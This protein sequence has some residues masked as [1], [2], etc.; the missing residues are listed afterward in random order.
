MNNPKQNR[1]TDSELEALVAKLKPP[2]ADSLD[3]NFK[4]EL[5]FTLQNSIAKSKKPTLNFNFM[6]KFK[7]I[8]ASASAVAIVALIF[9]ALPKDKGT[10][11]LSHDQQIIRINDKAF[12]SLA[13]LTVAGTGGRGGGGGGVGLDSTMSAAPMSTDAKSL[14]VPPGMGGGGG[15]ESFA[16]TSYKFIYKGDEFTI[17]SDKM[18]VYERQKGFGSFVNLDGVLGNFNIGSLNIGKFGS[19]SVDYLTASQDTDQGY[20]LNMDFR[21]GNLY[22]GQNWQRWPNVYA[23]C[24][25]DQNC[26]A[27]K[28]ITEDQLPSNEE[29]IAISNQFLDEYGIDKS[30]FGEPFVQDQWRQDYERAADKSSYY[31]PEIMSVIY[32]LKIEGNEIYDQGGNKSGM[33]VTVDARSKKVSGVSELNGQRYQASDYDTEKDAKRIISV[34]EKGGYQNYYTIM[35]GNM[36]E[37]EIELGNPTSG[38]VRLWQYTNNQSHELFVPSL[39]FPVTNAPK[40]FYAK[41][42]IVPIVKEVLDGDKNQPVPMPM[43]EKLVK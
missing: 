23:S 31:I 2:G 38:Y 27:Q 40:N 18:P 37:E 22:I 10:M 39:I 24:G 8:L 16:P 20:T 33:Y 35:G 25:A 3:Q 11:L 32:P 36:K 17:D 14:P 4:Q 9:F 1:M 19:S 34:A 43:M 28:R 15:G 29:A 30:H 13:T 26:F 5:Y 41:N 12:G 21:E 42:V 6:N 7:Y